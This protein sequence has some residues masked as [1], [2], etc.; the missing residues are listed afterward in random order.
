MCGSHVHQ[1][2]HSRSVLAG[3]SM[4]SSILLL[5]NEESLDLLSFIVNIQFTMVIFYIC[6]LI[7]VKSKKFC[8]VL[9]GAT[10]IRSQQ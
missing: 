6:L 5:I 1:V 4:G 7:L 10:E 9:H 2:V 3:T 8:C